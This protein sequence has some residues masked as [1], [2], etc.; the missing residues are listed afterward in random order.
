[1]V[2][3]GFLSLGSVRTSWWV[4]ASFL[5]EEAVRS[6]DLDRRSV[7]GPGSP[8]WSMSGPCD[9]DGG[10]TGRTWL[11]RGAGDRRRLAR[12]HR[13]PPIHSNRVAGWVPGQHAPAR[14]PPLRRRVWHVRTHR[15]SGSHL[16]RESFFLVEV[17]NARF[18]ARYAQRRGLA[19]ARWRWADGQ[20]S[21]NKKHRVAGLDP[22]STG[23]T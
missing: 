9:L 20:V 23:Q 8:V 7:D 1:M 22:R 15:S 11:I 6:M 14:S 19:V 10:G 21:G 13:A 12:A 16:P 17:C 2:S 3:N 5:R 4:P 18:P